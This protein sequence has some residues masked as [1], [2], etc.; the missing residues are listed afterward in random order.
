[1]RIRRKAREYA[2]QM[3]FQWE[4]ERADPAVIQAS[5]WREWPVKPDTRAFADSLFAGTVAAVAEIDALLAAHAEHWRLE[6]MAAVDRNLLRLA[7]HELQAHPE[8]PPAVVIDEA[9]EIARRFSTEDA[10]EFL[11]GI[12]DAVRKTLQAAPS[13]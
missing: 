10:V 6:R 8:T 11:N 2:L 13:G 5:F 9:L 12:L 4:G 3:L 1:M 7:V